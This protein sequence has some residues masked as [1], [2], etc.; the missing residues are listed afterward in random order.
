MRILYRNFF[1][2]VKLVNFVLKEVIDSVTR[3]MGLTFTLDSQT[4]VIYVTLVIV[5]LAPVK[6]VLAL[7]MAVLAV[8]ILAEY[9][10]LAGCC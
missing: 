9:F 8:V 5:P 1:V 7:N 10:G 4:M 2:L 3:S 6:S